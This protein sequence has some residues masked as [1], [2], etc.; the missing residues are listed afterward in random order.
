MNR[1]LTDL[2]INIKNVVSSFMLLTNFPIKIAS[3]YSQHYPHISFSNS[4]PPKFLLYFFWK[5]CSYLFFLLPRTFLLCSETLILRRTWWSAIKVMLFSLSYSPKIPGRA[6]I[7]LVVVIIIMCI[8]PQGND[9]EILF[10]F[11][12]INCFMFLKKIVLVLY[13][14]PNK[15]PFQRPRRIIQCFCFLEYWKITH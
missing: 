7:Q 6:D 12:Y 3:S 11:E 1:I 2:K 4:Q 13:G 15:L 14:F 5:S 10:S 8:D 9:P